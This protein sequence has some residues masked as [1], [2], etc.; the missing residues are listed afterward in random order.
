MKYFIL[1]VFLLSSIQLSAQVEVVAEQDQERNL[2]LIAFNKEKIPYTIQIEFL[3]LENLKSLKGNIILATAEPGKTNLV[4]LQSIYSNERTGFQYNTKLFK[5]NY[6]ETFQSNLSYLIPGEA[7]QRVKMSPLSVQYN[8][9]SKKDPYTGVGFYFEQ[10][11]SIVSP[12]KGII[13]E[14][15]MDLDPN[16]SGPSNFDSENYVEIYHEDGTFTRLSG[17]KKSSETVSV[18]D[19]VYPSQV[20]AISGLDVNQSKQHVKM[21]QSR[22]EFGENGMTWVNFPVNLFTEEGSITSS[23]EI[24]N[25]FISHPLDLITQEMNK[26]ELKKFQKK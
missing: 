8:D 21:V 16:T 9:P 7:D 17:L 13:S 1:A 2:T 14:M 25:T 19:L 5:G 18:G 23:E 4:N 20:I 24:S 12:R 26:K 15:K 3:K 10:E 22:W 11:V 6:R